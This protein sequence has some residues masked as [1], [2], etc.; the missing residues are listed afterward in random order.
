MSDETCIWSLQAPKGLPAWVSVRGCPCDLLTPVFRVVQECAALGIAGGPDVRGELRS[1][2]SH[3]GQLMAQLVDTVQ[4]QDNKLQEAIQYYTAFSQHAHD[5]KSTDT[6]DFLTTLREV[7]DDRTAEPSASMVAAFNSGSHS[8][9]SSKQN[10]AAKGGDDRTAASE[11]AAISWDFAV[12]DTSAS[13]AAD[14]PQPVVDIAWDIDVSATAT[15]D[16]TATAGGA[17]NIDW[18]I[19]LTAGG[20]ESSAQGNGATIS[21]D[22]STDEAA[23]G[24]AGDDVLSGQR[25]A[26]RRL[27]MDGEYRACFLDDL[28]ELRAFLSKVRYVISPVFPH[29]MFC[30]RYTCTSVDTWKGRPRLM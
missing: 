6:D 23:S 4:Q 22:I 2:T 16:A 24:N 3:L 30:L 10:T 5:L 18:G 15:D 21:W 12:E 9:T 11:P 1:L 17:V 26:V 8:T 14:T 20:E 27:V 7:K 28:L 29:C 25:S 19:D 13:A